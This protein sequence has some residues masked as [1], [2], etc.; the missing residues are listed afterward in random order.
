MEQNYNSSFDINKFTKES[1]D[2]ASLVKDF[3]FI[4][5]R[6]PEL[7]DLTV[8]LRDAVVVCGFT[9]VLVSPPLI[10]FGYVAGLAWYIAPM[11]SLIIVAVI[12]LGRYEHSMNKPLSRQAMSSGKMAWEHLKSSQSGKAEV[13]F[14]R[15]EDDMPFQA[16]GR[17]LALKFPV[18]HET[19]QAIA[20]VCL[21]ANNFSSRLLTSKVEGV[22][23]ANYADIK[24]AFLEQGIIRLKGKTEH[25][26][27]EIPPKGKAMLRGLAHSPTAL[28]TANSPDSGQN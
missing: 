22:T 15:W 10:I 17:D 7:T 11:S 16:G 28:L 4:Q 1:K 8:A 13:R 26:G 5:Y 6:A 14:L 18:S 24:N 3:E 19:L 21:E 23:Q 20:Q 25:A 12:G 9:L 27:F 2:A